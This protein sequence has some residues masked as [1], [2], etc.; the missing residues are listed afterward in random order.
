MEKSK[1]LNPNEK[2]NE[3]VKNTSGGSGCPFWIFGDK[4]SANNDL[5]KKFEIIEDEED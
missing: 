2:P 1:T 4:D 5:N 3:R